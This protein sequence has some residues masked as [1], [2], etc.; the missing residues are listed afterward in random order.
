MRGYLPGVRDV[1][2]GTLCMLV[3]FAAMSKAHDLGWYPSSWWAYRLAGVLVG[4]VLAFRRRYPALTF[5]S[6][7]AFCTAMRP[8]AL[9]AAEFLLAPALLAAWTATET[10]RLRPWVTLPG[11]LWTALL[12]FWPW[13]LNN[14]AGQLMPPYNAQ[15]PIWQLDTSRLGVMGLAC[16]ATVVLADSTGRHRVLAAQLQ[17]RNA[18][19]ERLRAVEAEQVVA[20]ERTRIARELHDIVAHHITAIVLR[21]QAADRVADARPE[22]PREAVRWIATT[23]QETLTSMRHVV[24]VLRG[25]GAG[26]A[27]PGAGQGGPVTGARPSVAAPLHPEAGL[28]DLPAVAHRMAEVGMQVEV[29]DVVPALPLAVDLAVARIVQESLTNA[30]VHGRARRARVEVTLDAGGD[31]RVVVDDD[32]VTGPPEGPAP[33][34]HSGG[35][36]GIVG[37]R[38]RAA[39]HG[40]DLALEASPWGGWRV[41]AHLRGVREGAA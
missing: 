29:P 22:E 38:E 32:G 3:W 14:A 12:L 19:L 6:V 4:L 30:L 7:V 10:R 23:G 27:A 25:G 1:A 13:P 35:G 17:L 8:Q 36:N 18:E 40:G 31:V 16:V 33:V 26:P 2:L 41:R 9:S 28:V 39:A 5:L 37:M 11:L 15:S 21:A 34:S 20:A 24:R